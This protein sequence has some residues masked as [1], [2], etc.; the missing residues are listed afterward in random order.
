MKQIYAKVFAAITFAGVGYG[1]PAFA[2]DEA[3]VMSMCNTYAAHHLHVSTSAIAD[4]KYEGQRS[5]GTRVVNGSTTDGHTF[6]CSFN[7][8]GTHVVS[9]SHTAATACPPDVSQADRYMYPACN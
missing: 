7:R 9:W 3:Q 4:L 1:M 8:A 2:F 5:D 6:Q